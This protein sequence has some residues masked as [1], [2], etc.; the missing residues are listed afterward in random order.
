MYFHNYCTLLAVYCRDR[1]RIITTEIVLLASHEISDE[2]ERNPRPVL[3]HHQ[4][5]FV[6]ILLSTTSNHKVTASRYARGL[7]FLIH[8]HLFN[9][10]TILNTVRRPHDKQRLERLKKKF[11]SL[12][13]VNSRCYASNRAFSCTTRIAYTNWYSTQTSN[14]TSTQID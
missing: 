6:R 7:P 10:A 9:R 2:Q 13:S 11:D 3:R 4:A 1:T 8:S 5:D 12:Q 14:I